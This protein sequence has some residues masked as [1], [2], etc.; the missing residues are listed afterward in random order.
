MGGRC[1]A[2]CSLVCLLISL[3]SLNRAR[4]DWG[5]WRR[6]LSSPHGGGHWRNYTCIAL[7]GPRHPKS[8]QPPRMDP[9]I[10]VY[11]CILFRSS[12][13]L[14]APPFPNSDGLWPPQHEHWPG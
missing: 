13:V 10:Y 14:P 7:W 12:L 8:G 3:C 5:F 1:L 11:V 2:V 9:W 4:L 6:R